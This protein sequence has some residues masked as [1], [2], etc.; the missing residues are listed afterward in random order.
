M[1][2]RIENGI[3]LNGVKYEAIEAPFGYESVC[4]RCALQNLC[5]E[6]NFDPCELFEGEI[7]FRIRR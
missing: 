2:N 7:Q 3:I 5:D 4:D 1:A 6:S